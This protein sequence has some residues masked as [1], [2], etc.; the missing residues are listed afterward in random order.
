MHILLG[1]ILSPPTNELQLLMSFPGRSLLRKR[2]ARLMFGL[3]QQT[4]DLT[5][6]DCRVKKN[7]LA[8]RQVVPY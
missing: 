8:A 4:S 2:C 7:F 5:F 3:F 1:V 6:G